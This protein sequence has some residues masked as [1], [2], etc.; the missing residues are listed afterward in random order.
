MSNKNPEIAQKLEFELKENAPESRIQSFL[1]DPNYWFGGLMNCLDSSE[2]LVE[3]TAAVSLTNFIQFKFNQSSDDCELL[4]NDLK[5]HVCIDDTQN[6]DVHFKK[7]LIGYWKL[8]N[9]LQLMMDISFCS[10]SMVEL[11]AEVVVVP[12]PTLQG[13]ATG[14]WVEV[15]EQTILTEGVHLLAELGNHIPEVGYELTVNEEIKGLAEL[16]WVHHKVALFD[17]DD[18]DTIQQF[19]N[20]GWQ[21]YVA[22]V[23]DELIEKL[24]E[25]LGV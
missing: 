11:N 20:D 13:E 9:V 16:A 17:D 2:Q 8:Y 18:Q 6:D 10:K 1:D 24:K 5:V 22:P 23:N 15:Y 7:S 3:L 21:C 19:I 4:L 12:E 14:D 25:K